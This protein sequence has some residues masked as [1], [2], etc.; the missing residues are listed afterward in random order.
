[1]K[2]I[3]S[4]FIKGAFVIAP[5]ALTLFIVFKVYQLTDGIFKGLLQRVG[6]YFPGLGLLI[7]LSIVFISGLMASNWFTKRLMTNLD[8]LLTKIPLLG[9]IYG[10]IRETVN[11]FSTK[12]NFNRVVM[13]HFPN[14]L[15]LLGF[16]TNHE[17][18]AFVPPGFVSVYIMQSMQ[19]AGYL[20]IIP[21]SQ[22]ETIDVAPEVALKFIASAGLLKNI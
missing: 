21:E 17:A 14:N 20:A 15:N 11:S 1:M 3:L 2:K 16:V 9:M 5:T 13:V 19:W 22:V 18:N 4:I 6:F 10:T 8:I 7:T 12:R